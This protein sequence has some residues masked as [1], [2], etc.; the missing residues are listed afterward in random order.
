MDSVTINWILCAL[1]C[2]ITLF[3]VVF[4]YIDDKRNEKNA[5]SKNPKL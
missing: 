3:L 5:L 4:S 1:I 2:A